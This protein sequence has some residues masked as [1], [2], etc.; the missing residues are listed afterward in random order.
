MFICFGSQ[1]SLNNSITHC[2]PSGFSLHDVCKS[3][4]T[5]G[6]GQGGQEQQD[7]LGSP[8]FPGCS[9]DNGRVDAAGYWKYRSLPGWTAVTIE[10]SNCDKIG[11]GV[12][13]FDLLSHDLNYFFCKGFLKTLWS[14][15]VMILQEI[16][17]LALTWRDST[18]SCPF[19]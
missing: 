4:P 17:N 12:Q 7:G 14:D 3:T 19:L 9:P 18:L 2:A 13:M 8:T 10:Y 5:S 6:W 16:W 15:M 11:I 1:L